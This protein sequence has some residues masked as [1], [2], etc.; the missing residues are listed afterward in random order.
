MCDKMFHTHSLL[1]VEI[2]IFS[3]NYH[4]YFL[5]FLAGDI[6][7]GCPDLGQINTTGGTLIFCHFSHFHMYKLER[8]FFQILYT[9]LRFKFSLTDQSETQKI[10]NVG[11][12]GGGDVS[13]VS[14]DGG[15]GGLKRH[16]GVYICTSIL[17]IC[18]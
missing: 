13:V 17:N 4:F 3:H 18:L 15:G 12:A 16:A 5:I 10:Q 9:I 8:K 7:S 2:L 14:G 6:K 11:S 1:S